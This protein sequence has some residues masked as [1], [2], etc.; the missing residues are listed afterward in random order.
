MSAT[1]QEHSNALVNINDIWRD[2][3]ICLEDWFEFQ[4]D[5]DD[6]ID[7][8]KLINTQEKVNFDHTCKHD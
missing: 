7:I 6:I 3:W 8:I 2:C 4:Y 1:K 5:V